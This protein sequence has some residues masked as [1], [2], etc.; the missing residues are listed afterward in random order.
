MEIFPLAS[1]SWPGVRSSSVLAKTPEVSIVIDPGCALGPRRYGLPPHRLEY[2][3]LDLAWKTISAALTEADV[4]VITHYHYDHLN[5]KHPELL[6]GKT[7]LVKD[8]QNTINLN[9]RRRAEE[10]L[11]GLEF[12]PADEKNFRF[13]ETELIFSEPLPHGQEGAKTGWVISLTIRRGQDS[14][15]YASDVG[16]IQTQVQFAFIA[17]NR[18]Q[19]LYIDGPLTYMGVGDLNVSVGYLSR[20]VKELKPEVIILEHH[21]LRDLHWR[22]KMAAVLELGEACGVRI[23]TAAG[24]VGRPETFLE[25]KRKELY[26]ETL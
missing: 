21:L 17:D 20:L 24:F 15:V 18:P 23:T 2:D 4:V 5:P 6:Q 9:Q 19:V 11:K 10:F 26:G 1:E 3:A 12:S 16:G 8:P 22:E 14:F 7:L 13:G 25:A